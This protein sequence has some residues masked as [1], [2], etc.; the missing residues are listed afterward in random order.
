MCAIQRKT[1]VTWEIDNYVHDYL[2]GITYPSTGNHG[3][4]VG[5]FTVL[6]SLIFSH[7][8]GIDIHARM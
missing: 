5:H 6:F 8:I 7:D 3:S 2:Y 4:Y 1:S